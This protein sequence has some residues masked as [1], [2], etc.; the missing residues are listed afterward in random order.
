M[1]PVTSKLLE[2]AVIYSTIDVIKVLLEKGVHKQRE[3]G[4]EATLNTAVFEKR[5]GV[6]ALSHTVFTKAVAS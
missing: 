6:V 5:Q 3:D 2:Q 1:H 4:G